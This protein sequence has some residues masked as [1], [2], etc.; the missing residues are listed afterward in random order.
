M[1]LPSR[2]QV[3]D[4]YMYEWSDLIS[5]DAIDILID[6]T[7]K[8]YSSPKSYNTLSGWQKKEERPQDLGQV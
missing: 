4:Y 7:I 6:L 5:R 3:E 8:T 2:T 1:P